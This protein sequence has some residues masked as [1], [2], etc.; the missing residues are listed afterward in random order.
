MYITTWIQLLFTGAPEEKMMD[1]T[2]GYVF[3]SIM[4]GVALE[5]VGSETPLQI[6]ITY[7]MVK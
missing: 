7:T 5:G 3:E 4:A 2:V 6:A 1:M